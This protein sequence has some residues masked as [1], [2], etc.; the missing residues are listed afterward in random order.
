MYAVVVLAFYLDSHEMSGIS[1][2][3]VCL[4]TMSSATFLICQRYDFFKSMLLTK[5]L[6]IINRPFEDSLPVHL[7]SSC[8]SGMFATS[9]FVNSLGLCIGS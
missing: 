3:I 5:R 8:A 4:F 2:R 9:E 1:S 6:P 7:V